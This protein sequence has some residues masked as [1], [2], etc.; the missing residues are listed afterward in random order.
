MPFEKN[1]KEIVPSIFTKQELPEK[2]KTI[3]QNLNKPKEK[4]YYA[5]FDTTEEL[6]LNEIELNPD[7]DYFWGSFNLSVTGNK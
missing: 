4:H 6:I 3:Q 1:F 2:Y 7:I 5:K